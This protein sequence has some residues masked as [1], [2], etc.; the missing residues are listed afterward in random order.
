MVLTPS[1]CLRAADSLMVPKKH[2]DRK[3]L[4]PRPAHGHPQTPRRLLPSRGTHISSPMKV[5]ILKAVTGKCQH[6]VLSLRRSFNIFS[7]LTVL[8][9]TRKQR[10]GDSFIKL[11]SLTVPSVECMKS[12]QTAHSVQ[13][14]PLSSLHRQSN[15][16]MD[17]NTH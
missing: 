3:P 1:L 12:L 15:T 13:T 17:Q 4:I 5:H 10:N 8:E 2:S 14:S 16:E 11:F 6:T 7:P 9:A